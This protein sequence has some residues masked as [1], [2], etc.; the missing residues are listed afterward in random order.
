MNEG[1]KGS[2]SHDG[3]PVGHAAGISRVRVQAAIAALSARPRVHALVAP[4]VQPLAADVASAL[5]VDISMTD[6]AQAVR[7]MAGAADALTINLGMLADSRFETAKVLANAG[8]PFLLDPVK[9]DRSAPRL[10]L[11]QELLQQ[12]PAIVKGNAAEMAVLGQLPRSAVTVTTGPT[13]R[14]N[15]GRQRYDLNNG[16]RL[17][18]AVT[19]T[20]CAAGV[21]LSALLG[22]GASS[23]DATVAGLSLM[24]C[25]AERAAKVSHGPG[26]FKIAWLDALAAISAEE[27][28]A[29][30][31]WRYGTPDLSVYLIVGPEHGDGL[32]VAQRAVEGGVSLV[33]YRDKSGSTQEQ[34]A[35]VRRLVEGLTVPVLVNVR[36]EVAVAAGAAGVHVGHGDLT[37]WQARELVGAERIVGVTVHSMDEAEEFDGAPIDYASVGGVFV[38]TSKH[39]PNPPI[40]MDGFRRISAR[41]RQAHDVPICAIAGIDA[42][43]AA[44]L[45]AAGADGVAVISAITSANDP[46]VAAANLSAAIAGGRT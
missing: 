41:L 22:A 20:G 18:D 37:P 19:G 31:V 7:A 39:N 2:P 25:A 32:A 8:P 29:D 33:Q 35:A 16:H 43:R 12:S 4:V 24:N 23:F 26:S 30:M 46:A 28:A 27:I 6:D 13:D 1:S 17:L 40:G 14:V 5:G 45:A 11:A 15:A 42:A 36:A 34:V 3:S 9:V 10:A 44:E 38:T 21:V